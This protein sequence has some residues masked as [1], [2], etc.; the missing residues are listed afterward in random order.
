MNVLNLVCFLC[1]FAVSWCILLKTYGILLLKTYHFDLFLNCGGISDPFFS[2]LYFQEWV[3]E[4]YPIYANGPGY[5]VSANI[6]EFIVSEFE[7]GKLKVCN[8][9]KPHFLDHLFLIS[10]CYS[11]PSALVYMCMHAYGFVNISVFINSDIH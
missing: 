1:R 8:V 6:A 10:I 7:K 4:A 3:E 9:Y 5:I 11:L 2:V